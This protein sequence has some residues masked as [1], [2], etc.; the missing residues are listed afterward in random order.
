MGV[1]SLSDIEDTV[2]QQTSWDAGDFSPLSF[3]SAVREVNCLSSMIALS[4]RVLGGIT[5]G[6]D[7]KVI[8]G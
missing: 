1:A 4:I 2:S 6:Y 5:T 7:V 8:V 3:N